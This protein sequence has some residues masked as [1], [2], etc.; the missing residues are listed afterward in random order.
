MA[1]ISVNF[2]ECIVEHVFIGEVQVSTS[3]YNFVRLL[4]VELECMSA[5]DEWFAFCRLKFDLAVFIRNQNSSYHI[6]IV[7][8]KFPFLQRKTST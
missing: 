1:G 4:L 6:K 2:V 7:K 8:L 5:D 3:L